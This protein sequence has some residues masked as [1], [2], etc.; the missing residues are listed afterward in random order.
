MLAHAIE[1]K[2]NKQKEEQVHED[3]TLRI[4]N[5]TGKIGL[6]SV[7]VRDAAH[8]C[9]KETSSIPSRGPGVSGRGRVSPR[10]FR[11]L[12]ALVAIMLI[13]LPYPESEAQLSGRALT[14]RFIIP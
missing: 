8:S 11:T 7:G 12:A 5:N 3:S 13:T 4:L 6:A 1:S 2:A 10:S 14:A 9:E